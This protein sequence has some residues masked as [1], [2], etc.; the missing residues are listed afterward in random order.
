MSEKRKKKSSFPIDPNT[1]GICAICLD[2]IT[3]P[4]VQCQVGHAHCKSC[5]EASGIQK[6]P[7]CRGNMS[8]QP[9]SIELEQ[10][11]QVH[12]LTLENSCR[13][14]YK[15]CKLKIDQETKE[16]HERECRFRTFIC[17][18]K[19]FAGWKCNWTGE[20]S[21]IEQHFKQHHSDKN[22]M[23]FKTEASS[24]VN[25]QTDFKDVHLISFFNGQAYFYYKHYVN[26][27]KQ[28]IYW[29]FQYIG[30]Q[31]KARQY[32]YEFEIH[33]GPLRKFKVSEQCWN[34]VADANSLFQ[35]EK[36]VVMSFTSAKNFLNPEGEL[37]FRF[38]ILK[39]TN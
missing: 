9:R 20:Y 24:K 29:L 27:E 37:S 11:L 18:G 31:S 34:D 10:L 35:F 19:K 14:T 25:F 12:K 28:K 2:I 39:T 23:K 26:V 4:L 33:K 3:P 32:F 38:R 21:N 36:C 17:E 13:F 15:G 8:L 16:N 7:T 22:L 5:F 6:C 30:L 1:L